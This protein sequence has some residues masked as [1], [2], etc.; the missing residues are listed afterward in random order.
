MAFNRNKNN[1]G[2]DVGRRYTPG[3]RTGL[4]PQFRKGSA[5]E[6]K[7]VEGRRGGFRRNRGGNPNR[8]ERQNKNQDNKNIGGRKLI[9]KGGVKPVPKDKDDLDRQMR[10]YW[11]K[12]GASKGKEEAQKQKNVASEKMNE[13][14]DFYW[15]EAALKK[16]KK[17][18]PVQPQ[19]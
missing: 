14:M 8:F 2:D 4:K 18:E 19:V 15:K 7:N 16:Q 1:K 11:I 17:E 3:G 6:G 13:E 10:Q 12:S 5:D 9:K